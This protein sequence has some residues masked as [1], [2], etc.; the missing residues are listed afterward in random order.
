MGSEI[1]WFLAVLALITAGESK[2]SV[3]GT[4]HPN[5]LK[6]LR[7]FKAGIHSDDSGRINKWI[8]NSCCEWDG[9]SCNNITGRVTQINLPGF[10]T[11]DD[12]PLQAYMY[13]SISPSITLLSNLEVVDLSGLVG[14]TGK[15]PSLIGFHLP[16]LRKL[17]LWGNHIEGPLPESIALRRLD[18]HSNR[19]SGAIPESIANLTS[20]ESL[21]LQNNLLT[22]DIPV[23][24]GDLQALKELDLSNNS[25]TGKIPSS[26]TKLKA[27]S[28][29]YLNDNQLVG[30]IP[31]LL[32]P[33]Q[34]PCL[35]FL[36]VKN[37][38]LTGRIP[39]SFGYLSSLQRVSLANN[40][41]EGP[42]PS[43]LG[44]LRSLT[45]LYLNGNKL[46]GRLPSSISLLSQLIMLTLSNNM[47]E[48]PLPHQMAS[49]GNL[50]ML[51][52]SFNWLNLSTI[53]K[54]LLKLPSLSRIYLAD[55]KIQGELPEDLRATPSAL[56]ELDLSANHLSGKI[57]EWIGSL[58]ELYSLNLSV[59]FL[60]G[61]L[62]RVFQVESRF[63]TGGS[64][65]SL[66]L[67]DNNFTS[68]IEQIGMGTQ[69]EI[70]HINLSHNSIEGRLPDS[71]G[72]L[73]TM[74][75]LDLSCNNLD[76]ALPPLLANA[77]SLE[78]L[79]LR[80]NHFTGKIPS[81]FLKLRKLKELDL[82]DNFLEGKI[83]F[84]RPLINFPRVSYSGNK[85]L[86]GLPLD[87]CRP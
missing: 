19:F 45:E 84:G 50:Q 13:G 43:S 30:E 83:P 4:C 73:E 3:G 56:Q 24:I 34:M 71:I 78:T 44:D 62:Q 2:K 15:I 8:G 9:I 55:C 64:L 5:D 28:I 80:K 79:K 49:L 38:R 77:S 63:T 67:S 74:K 6:G 26:I 66:D 60:A 76:S 18:L 14:L 22:G 27:V 1:L 81:E 16:G 46:S 61:S 7:S 72:R 58:T 25:L 33:D 48:G 23:K 54:W 87:P 53:P 69:L 42:I 70:Q 51:D 37:N 12:A 39:Y 10:I 21:S 59:N 52:L 32:G 40:E 41:L 31:T 65:A 35:G 11:T 20:L 36:R 57:P 17:S 29:I 68:G 82:S 75:S 85:G 86:C 47:I